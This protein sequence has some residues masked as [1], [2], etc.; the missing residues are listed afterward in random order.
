MAEEINDEELEKV[1]KEIKEKISKKLENKPFL[2]KAR[3][4][5]EEPFIST[6]W[7]ENNRYYIEIHPPYIRDDFYMSELGPLLKYARE[8][9]YFT[10]LD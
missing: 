4:S 3:S 7:V 10:N 5:E 1:I 8:K 6:R 2:L 9:G